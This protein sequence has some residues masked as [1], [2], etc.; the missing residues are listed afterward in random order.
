[1][2]KRFFSQ[3]LLYH[4]GRT[5]AFSLEEFLLFDTGYPLITMIFY[6]LLAAYSFG[7]SDLSYWVVG[8]AFLLCTNTCVFS[9]GGI[10][11]GERYYGRLRTIVAAPCS[12]LSLI[13][14]SGVFPALQSIVTVSA[15]FLIGGVVFGM[16]FSNLNWGLAVFTVLCAMISAT[17][18]G[19]FIAVFG[20]VSDSMHLILNVVSYVLIIFTGAEFPVSQLPLIGQMI[21]KILPLTHSLQAMNLLF[22]HDQGGFW[23]LLGTELFIAVCYAAAARTI[24][25]VVERIARQNGRFDVF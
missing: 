1:M 5:A 20:L 4:K 23:M 10:F 24:F 9:L 16:D 15:G 13:L 21:S 3:A 14:A 6:C 12:K 11:G 22:S 18:F 17:C 7:T 2:I 25:G 8:N 19:L